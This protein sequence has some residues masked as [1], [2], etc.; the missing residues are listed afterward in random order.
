MFLCF[1]ISCFR[2]PFISH[3][4]CLHLSNSLK[5]C[6]ESLADSA[7]FGSRAENQTKR[8]IAHHWL[9]GNFSA[10]TECIT[11]GVG[12]QMNGGDGQRCSRCY[13]VVHCDSACAA[14]VVA[15]SCRPL[16]ERLLLTQ[17]NVAC[18]VPADERHPL[19]V[20]VNSRSGGGEGAEIAARL[21]R[22]LDERQV[23]LLEQ[24]GPAAG[25]AR[26]AT[27]SGA[28]LLVCGGDGT[29]NW[30]LNNVKGV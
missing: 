29:V 9:R 6:K 14:R 20:F 13:T 1:C 10:S 30:V 21:R 19:C 5:N 4:E 23:Y 8:A 24:G 12:F 3:D 2:S 15:Q 22:L 27:V 26:F 28:R 7:N 18:N 16:H 17:N 11:C 25:L